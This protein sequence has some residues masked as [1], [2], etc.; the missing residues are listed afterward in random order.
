[1]PSIAIIGAGA[2]GLLCAGTALEHGANVTLFDKNAKAGVK[3]MITGKGRCNVTNNSSIE[4][5]L[6]N[7]PRNP[8]FLYGAL[9][10]FS[11]NDTIELFERLGVPLKTER[12]SRVFPV[13]D[14]ASDIVK[15]LAAYA[16]KA[17]FISEKVISINTD[18]NSVTGV[19]ARDKVG[20]IKNY[21]FD[22][23][24]LCTGG[25]SYPR[26]GSTGDGYKIAK[27]IGHNI[28]PCSPSLVPIEADKRLCSSLSGL[29]LRNVSLKIKDNE[30]NKIVYE[31]FGEMLFAHFGITG[32]IALSASA[33]LTK[34][35]PGKYCAYIDLKPALDEKT[36]DS[37]LLADFSKY[38][39]KNFSN[40]LGDL[41]P[42]KMIPAF[43][44]LSQISP[45]KKVNMITK[46]ERHT[47]VNLLKNFKIDLYGFRPIDEAI[48]TSGGIDVKEISPKDMQ[49]KLISGLYFAG[50]VIDVDAYTGG[51]NLQI[52]FS[53]G[54]LAGKNA[55]QRYL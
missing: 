26:T 8:R 36:L 20:N 39:N 34:P 41:L 3:L 40:A 7:I 48:V 5:I 4:N 19:T 53:T 23:V 6:N 31:E 25:L 47:L 2:A 38:I 1:M 12:G 9:N 27:E 24:I 46:D 50:E 18:N 14:K 35:T 52:A 13:S 33:H 51:Y 16:K 44:K 21:D 30:Q 29:S 32:P 17:T 49:S 22:S 54:Y 45:D 28:I 15:A 37:R 42:Q 55:A 10:A 11:P 43:I